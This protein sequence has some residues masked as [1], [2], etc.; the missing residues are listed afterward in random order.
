MIPKVVSVEA[1]TIEEAWKKLLEGEGVPVVPKEEYDYLVKIEG[2][3]TIVTRK[4][5]VKG[6]AVCHPEDDFDVR[7]GFATALD[8]LEINNITLNTIEKSIIQYLNAIGVEKFYLANDCICY[9]VE[10]CEED[11]N[12]WS[13][14][15]LYFVD[16]EFSTLEKNKVYRVKSFLGR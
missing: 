14:D 13:D 9:N 1:K 15:T 4:D 12:F 16:N 6:V 11:P 3:K 8:M 5:G 7:I 2:N 10:E